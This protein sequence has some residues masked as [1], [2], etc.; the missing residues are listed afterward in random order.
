MLR[1]FEAAKVQLDQISYNSVPLE[2][3]HDAAARQCLYRPCNGDMEN[4]SIFSVE[5]TPLKSKVDTPN[6]HV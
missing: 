3:N 6:S 1:D 2:G 4:P 5:I